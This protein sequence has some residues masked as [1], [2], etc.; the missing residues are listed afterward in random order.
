MKN[1]YLMLIILV[2]VAV[3]FNACYVPDFDQDFTR[4]IITD[5]ESEPVPDD[6]VVDPIEDGMDLLLADSSYDFSAMMSSRLAESQGLH[7]LSDFEFIVERQSTGRALSAPETLVFVL[8]N[9]EVFELVSYEDEEIIIHEPI[10][11]MDQYF[12]INEHMSIH[13]FSDTIWAD[14][15]VDPSVER[16]LDTSDDGLV[17]VIITMQLPF[18]QFYDRERAGEKLSEKRAKFD[19]IKARVASKIQQGRLKRDLHII[20][21]SS[22]EI[23]KD[24]LERLRRDPFVKKIEFDYPVHAI[25]DNSLDQIFAPDVWSFTDVNGNLLTGKDI[26]IGIIDTGIDYTHPDLGG[27]FG[28]GCKVQGG[29]DFVNNRDDPM[30]DHGHGTHCAA[31]A[32]G[33]GLL[34]GVA[35]DAILYGYKVLGSTGSGST[36][37]VIAA[38]DRSVADGLDVISLSLGSSGARPDDPSSLAIDRA[39]AA[40]VVAV[41]AAGNSGPSESTIGTPAAARTAIT[42]AASCKTNDASGHCSS[43]SS[44]IASFSSRGPL[45]YEGVDLK[46]PDISAPGVVICAARYG[47]YGSVTCMNSNRHIRISGTSMATPHVAGGAALMVQAYP[48]YTP[49]MIKDLMKNTARDLGRPYDE[50]GAGEID[51]KAAIPSPQQVVVNPASTSISTDPTTRYSSV[52]QSFSVTPTDDSNTLSISYNLPP[53][54][55]VETNKNTLQVSNQGTDS[56]EATITVDN[57]LA[58]PGNQMGVIL[59]TENDVIKGGIPLFIEVKPTLLVSPLDTIG[60]G[61]MNPEISSWSSE[62]KRISITNL[63]KDTNLVLNVD[64]SGFSSGVTYSGQS[65]VNIPADGTSHV[66]LKIDVDASE[67]GIGMHRGIIA[68]TKNSLV[69]HSSVAEFTRAYL[70]VVEKTDDSKVGYITVHNGQSSSRFS[71][72]EPSEITIMLN[73]P[74]P[75]DVIYQAFTRYPTSGSMNRYIVK[76]Q[77]QL[78]NGTAKVFVDASDAKNR[79]RLEATNHEGELIQRLFDSTGGLI[80]KNTRRVISSFPLASGELF[81][82]DLSED[83]SAHILGLANQNPSEENY[84]LYMGFQGPLTENKLFS[85]FPSSYKRLDVQLN[86]NKPDA[87]PRISLCTS[88]SCSTRGTT[89]TLDAPSIMSIYSSPIDSSFSIRLTEGTPTSCSFPCPTLFQTLN[90]EPYSGERHG[91]NPAL[92]INDGLTYLGTGPSIWFGKFLNSQNSMRIEGYHP[93]MWTSFIRQDYVYQ[94]YDEIPYTIS[95]AGNVVHSGTLR[96]YFISR[97][98]FRSSIL[99]S[100]SLGPRDVYEFRITD[101]EYLADGKLMK[102]NVLARFDTSQNNRNP[103][104]IRSFGY[105]VDGMRAEVYDSSKQNEVRV[106]IDPV[107]GSLSSLQ[108]GFSADGSSFSSLSVNNGRAILPSVN[109]N[110]ITLRIEATDS[111]NNMLQYTFEL[112]AGSVGDVSPGYCGDGVLNPGEECDWGGNNGQVCTPP[113]GGECTYCSNECKFVTLQGPPINVTKYS[114]SVDVSGEGSVS[115]PGI[116]CP[117]VCS[118]TFDENT[119]VALSAVASTGYEFSGWSGACSGSGNCNVVMN[120]N[121][122]VSASFV[123]QEDTTPPTVTITNP[124]QGDVVSGTITFSATASDNVGVEGVSFYQNG[125]LIGDVTSVPYSV[126][127]DSRSVPDGNRTLMARAR[128]AAGN[129]RED[130]VVI[131]VKNSV[132]NTPP[133]VSILTPAD[134]STLPPRGSVRFSTSAS[135][136]NSVSS[137]DLYINGVWQRSCSDST[138]CFTN[139]NVNRLSSGAHVIS[140]EATDNLGNVG[141][142]SATVQYP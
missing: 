115:G 84:L 98:G 106:D 140:V 122:S 8:N 25:L 27:C 52:T 86:P 99:A 50:Q 82:S 136:Q 139:W 19:E 107:G 138:T 128:D 131:V 102:A 109:A 36:S 69:M 49:N 44:P 73:N 116:S 37:N 42:V 28:D 57:D 135:S 14:E 87:N 70:L 88:T 75:F 97:A 112:P 35:P 54:V 80:Y 46:K 56:F 63:R 89:N 59:L 1:K 85:Y 29:Y 91:E 58:Q 119:S 47:N 83:Y 114:L 34:N 23:S 6:V 95:R 110:K 71:F 100:A 21:G 2:L 3:G 26:K 132:D 65:S 124:N 79:L 18:D 121:K 101:F 17:P 20:G 118:A 43:A 66:D 24:D 15:I 126:L 12:Q 51:I 31:T 108:I 48:S 30:D 16:V 92:T 61:N 53:G 96:N 38:I 64:V 113:A 7:K 105:F 74:G 5:P 76:E 45:I 39:T 40:G 125:V 32:A 137:I 10:P 111:S 93:G 22:A 77:V 103:P 13:S 134:G 130:S 90:I 78:S 55:S 123:A 9:G 81:F 94:E 104:S 68:L 120:S 117:G 62:T 11:D 129:T 33:K 72:F 4:P 67:V 142:A 133:T 141:T 127:W 60:F 41:V